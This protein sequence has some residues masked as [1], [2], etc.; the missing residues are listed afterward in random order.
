V[1]DEVDNKPRGIVRDLKDPQRET[2]KR[3]SQYLHMINVSAVP[4]WIGDEGSVANPATFEELVTRPGFV[5]WKRPNRELTRQEPARLPV[6]FFK[7]DDETRQDMFDIGNNPDVLGV[8]SSAASDRTSGRAIMLRQ[9]TGQVVLGTY[10]DNLRMTRKLLGIWTIGLIQQTFTDSKVIRLT[11]QRGSDKLVRLNQSVMGNNFNMITD[12][13][14]GEVKTLSDYRDLRF[15]VVI[16]ESPS[17]PSTR[18]AQLAILSDLM[19]GGAFQN[20]GL[21]DFVMEL[22]GFDPDTR[23]RVIQSLVPAALPGAGGPSAPGAPTGASAA[24]PA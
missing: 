6:E 3:R 19:N 11:G 20:P 14:T 7:L 13:R 9:Q 18:L 5:V 15:D 16:T 2:N 10:F 22:A 17:A 21:A 4:G 1:A 24:P 23:Q 12:M 8:E